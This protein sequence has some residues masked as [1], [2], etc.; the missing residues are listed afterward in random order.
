V[1]NIIPPHTHTFTLTSDKEEA[2]LIFKFG[3]DGGWASEVQG[4]ENAST[5]VFY[6]HGSEVE[7]I[8]GKESSRINMEDFLDITS[9]INWKVINEIKALEGKLKIKIHRIP[10][11]LNIT[12]IESMENKEITTLTAKW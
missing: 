1:G 6:I 8:I 11:G 3:N 4:K 10:R 12:L 7:I 9:D 5:S 2:P